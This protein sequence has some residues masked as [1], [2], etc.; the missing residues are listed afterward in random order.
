MI[1]SALGKLQAI[2]VTK[3]NIAF[4]SFLI[5]WNPILHWKLKMN[6]NFFFSPEI[7]SVSLGLL[8]S[9]KLFI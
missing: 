1:N 5:K 3:S 2:Y 9:K 8:T 4:E 6:F 7:S